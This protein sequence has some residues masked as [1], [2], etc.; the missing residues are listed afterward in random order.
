MK[1]RFVQSGGFVGAVRACELDTAAL[2]PDAAREVER[3]VG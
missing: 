3:L 2:A 1:V